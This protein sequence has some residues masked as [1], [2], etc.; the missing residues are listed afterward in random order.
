MKKF[1]LFPVV[2]ALAFISFTGCASKNYKTTKGP[3]G[4]EWGPNSWSA[5]SGEY[6][7]GAHF[8][9]QL[10]TDDSDRS[11]FGLGVDFDY[12][13]D[14]LFGLRFTYLQGIDDPKPSLMSLTPLL[15]TQYSNL[16]PML[17]FGPGIGLVKSSSGNR[18]AK[19]GFMTGLGADFQFVDH[20]GMGI[21]W[22][23]N[24]LFDAQD[25][26]HV[27]ARLYYIF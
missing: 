5:N 8:G 12:R 19:F 17:Y 16:R 27:G 1:F 4:S 15:H 21:L 13:P 20:F 7:V 3:V 25:F 9:A 10:N 18:E 6:Q 23:Y 22:Q 2:F 24:I 14:D 26:Q 11:S